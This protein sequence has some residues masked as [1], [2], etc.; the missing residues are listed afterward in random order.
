MSIEDRQEKGVSGMENGNKLVRAGGFKSV[1]STGGVPSRY[2]I[3]EYDENLAFI[4]L[5]VIIGHHL[6]RA[7]VISNF[8]T[9]VS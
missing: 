6:P 5:K 3:K 7:P 4:S 1:V 8:Y 2:L 9:F